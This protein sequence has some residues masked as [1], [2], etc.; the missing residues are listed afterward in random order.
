MTVQV[1]I[2]TLSILMVT[3]TLTAF[4]LPMIWQV[5]KASQEAD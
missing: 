1:D 5:K 4:L 3:I 2:L